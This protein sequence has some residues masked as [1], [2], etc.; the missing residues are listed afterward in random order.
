MQSDEQHEMLLMRSQ[1]EEQLIILQQQ[2]AEVYEELLRLKAQQEVSEIV[3]A[4][5]DHVH[6]MTAVASSQT[7]TNVQ[8]IT[9]REDISEHMAS[10]TDANI[11]SVMF[12][13]DVPE[14]VVSF[15]LAGVM[16]D[17]ENKIKEFEEELLVIRNE[18]DDALI[19]LS[20]VSTQLPHPMESMPSA[21]I[22]DIILM[23]REENAD[24]SQA[25][26]KID[27][28]TRLEDNIV[29]EM[30]DP[31]SLVVSNTIVPLEQQGWD[32]SEEEGWGWGSN[33]A[34]LE[35][36]HIQK[37]QKLLLYSESAE[38][39]HKRISDFEAQIKD[40]EIE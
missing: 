23:I 32:T 35:E 29:N 26:E 15:E 10:Q 14:R 22:D 37:Q 17:L 18:R 30:R 40:L 21:E 11:K 6:R 25:V 8:S 16:S 34:K 38:V 36:E 12:Q 1:Y 13:E 24:M 19:K 20:Q 5:E 28:E 33:E 9:F 3:H 27:S 39:L 4:A 31:E 2:K 7:D